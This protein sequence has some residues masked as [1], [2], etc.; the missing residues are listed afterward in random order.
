MKTVLIFALLGVVAGCGGSSASD[1]K[2]S[3]AAAFYPLAA[4]AREVGGTQVRVTDLTPPGAEP[5][6]LELTTDQVD[7]VL[8]ADLVV[9]MGRGFQPALE[10]LADD[11]D[12]GTV[13]VLR[14][15]DGDDPHVWLDP[16]RY[17]EIVGEVADGLATA[18][19]D[20]SATS[21]GNAA[22]IAK[23][24]AALD[25]ELRAGLAHCERD[26]IVTAHAAFGWLAKRYGLRQES[27]AGLSPDQEP[28]PKRVAELED[29]VRTDG[30][31]TIF[32]EE[33][34]S[35]KVAETL[36]REAGVRAEVLSPLEGLSKD[37]ITAGDDY[38]SVMRVNLG[39][40][41]TALGCT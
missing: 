28:N 2:V 29:L 39:K 30:V 6:D 18:D 35:P 12:G 21:Q 7:T 8:D 37:E 33:L 19:P 9:L 22:A 23:N 34:V 36:A 25:D 14:A 4:A 1:G 20:Q 11:R 40:L 27:I 24:L 5:H 15:T 16:T 41:R 32:T 17:A 13:E 10:D 38:D 26:E 3:V 31:T